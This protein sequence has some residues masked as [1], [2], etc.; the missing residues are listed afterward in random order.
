MGVV[1][2]AGG[3]KVGL[4]ICTASVTHSGKCFIGTHGEL[5]SVAIDGFHDVSID[6]RVVSLVGG[7]A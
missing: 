3:F 4:A 7:D 2:S 5:G 1:S 6:A